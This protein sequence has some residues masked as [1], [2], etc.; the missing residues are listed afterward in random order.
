M[1]LTL[2]LT[3]LSYILTTLLIDLMSNRTLE[4]SF[5]TAQTPRRARYLKVT[6][7]LEDINAIILRTKGKKQE[8]QPDDKLATQYSSHNVRSTYHAS[9]WLLW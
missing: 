2:G 9:H 6:S 3:F 1:V 8:E 4:V 7:W 5:L